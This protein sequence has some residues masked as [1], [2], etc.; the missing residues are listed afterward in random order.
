MAKQNQDFTIWGFIKG[1]GKLLVGTLLLLQGIVG[2]FAL[3]I[4]IGLL[5]AGVNGFSGANDVEKVPAGAALLIAPEAV[6][7]EQAEPEDPFASLLGEAFGGDSVGQLSVHD[8][9]YAIRSAADNEKISAI[10]LDIGQLAIS[11]SSAS[12][13][14]YVA[15][16]LQDFREATYEG[17]PKRI[18]AVGD[19]YEQSQYL[20]AAQ[21]DE[22]I[23]SDYG[24]VFIAGYGSYGLYF[25]SFLERLKVTTHVFRV[26][27]FKS[28]VEPF[29]RDDMSEEAKEA[30]RAFLNVL[31]DAYA[32]SVAEGRP[33]KLTVAAVKEYADRPA[34]IVR[35]AGGDL[36][37]AA[38]NHG[39]VDKLMSRPEQRAYL[40]DAFG[41]NDTGE[42]FLSVTLDEYLD[43]VS[44]PVDG[45]A[46]NVAVITVAGPIVD[47]DEVSTDVAA[48][49]TIGGYLKS[50][51]EDD[52]VKA[53]VLRVD[54]PGG[55][56]FASEVIR[57]GVIAL[58]QA[59][60]PVVASMGSL[61]AS[62]GYWV[63]APADE[64]W[65]APTTLTGSIGI[66]GLLTTL[67]EGAGSLGV[68][69]DG[70]GTSTLTPLYATGLGPLPAEASEL[71]Q[72]SIENGYDR[73][74]SIVAEG[75]NA[76]LPEDAQV[77]R[78]YLDSVAQGRVWI[79]EQAQRLRL[80]DNLGDFDDAVEAAARLAE[81]EAYD[82]V[83]MINRMTP[84]ERFFA[85]NAARAMALFGVNKTRSDVANSFVAKAVRAAEKHFGMLKHFNDPNGMYARC[86]ACEPR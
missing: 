65:A 70:I 78:A 47:G 81:L 19:F 6:L 39:L 14:H 17:E 35:R 4:F 12:K 11:Q 50:A 76:V 18:I 56:V 55:S 23:M 64:I 72:L 66:F 2:L 28:A 34:E 15:E 43:A 1:F 9:V 38:L 86:L 42:S 48:G 75:R 25:K 52:D 41:A 79:G 5:T 74:L 59:G 63:S 49:D 53:V 69:V 36:A 62:G 7:V 3:L 29:L 68:F 10:V 84:F 31:W 22:V 8:L 71:L 20:L 46:P 82:R 45:D 27:T 80:V 40:K 26:G 57:D 30:N 54:S 83:D 24:N 67:E 44:R 61:A 60:K 58:K 37:Q 73:F 77:D 85:T 21:A 32:K 33:E 13:L 51:L 16:A